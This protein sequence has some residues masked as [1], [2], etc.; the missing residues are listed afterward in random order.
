MVLN[1]F[2]VK[3]QSSLIDAFLVFF[4]LS[5]CSLVVVGS[6][7]SMKNRHVG[8]CLTSAP[9]LPNNTLVPKGRAPLKP[10]HSRNPQ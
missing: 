9:R 2:P 4:K 6:G 5:N 7:S 1:S 8:Y 3:E 10:R